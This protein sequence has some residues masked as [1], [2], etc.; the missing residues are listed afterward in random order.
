[1]ELDLNL[2][3]LIGDDGLQPLLLSSVRDRQGLH[4]LIKNSYGCKN[5][6]NDGKI[7]NGMN[8]TTTNDSPL[9]RELSLLLSA[10]LQFAD[11]AP[12]LCPEIPLKIPYT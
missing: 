8:V 12:W 3:E 10:Y 9:L 5:N 6:S 7:G 4:T 2:R 11:P 1:L